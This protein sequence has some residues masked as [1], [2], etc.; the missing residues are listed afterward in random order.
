MHIAHCTAKESSTKKITK[1]ENFV[2][3]P[4]VLPLTNKIFTNY[5]VIWHPVTIL[6]HINDE[7]KKIYDY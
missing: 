5:H 3:I 4:R 1:Q 6:I 7:N 2:I